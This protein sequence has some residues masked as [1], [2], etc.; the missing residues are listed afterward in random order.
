MTDIWFTGTLGYFGFKKKSVHYLN[1]STG[2]ANRRA[3]LLERAYQAGRE[4]GRPDP[5]SA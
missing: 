3:A 1:G 2:S 5:G 4:V